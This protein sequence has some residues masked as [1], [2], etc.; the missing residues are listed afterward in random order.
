M[1]KSNNSTLHINHAALFPIFI[2]VCLLGLIFRL[3]FVWEVGQHPSLNIYLAQTDMFNYDLMARD[4]LRQ[5]PLGLRMIGYPLFIHYL[6]FFYQ[7]FGTSPLSFYIHNYIL[8]VLSIFLLYRIG[9][10]H[11]GR[12]AGALAALIFIF[13]KMNY[14]YDAL[15]IHTALSQ[16]LIIASLYFF[17]RFRKNDTVISY[18]GFV[19]AGILL[20]FI[21]IF[22]GFLVLIGIGYLFIDK[23]HW[24]SKTYCLLNIAFCILS[25]IGFNRLHSTDTYRHKFGVHFYIGNHAD[26]SGVFTPIR[27]VRTH[28]QGFAQDTILKAYEETG[29]IE[30]INTYWLKKTVDSY[31]NSPLAVLRVLIKKINLFVNSYE[32]HNNASIYFYETNTALKYFPRIG[33]T[34]IF[35]L[36]LIGM[37][38]T[39][40]Y[41]LEGRYLI[42]PIILLSAMILSVFFC[43]RYRMPTIPFL[44]LFAGLGINQIVQFIKGRDYRSL[45]V[46]GVLAGLLFSWSYHKTPILDKDQDILFWEK[47]D[48][49]RILTNQKRQ[50]ALGDYRNWQKLDPGVKITL[51]GRLGEVG[52]VH[53][54]F[55]VYGEAYQLAKTMNA[56]KRLIY[57]MSV[58]A[59]LYEESFQLQKS[60]K[61]WQELA[62]VKQIEKIARQKIKTLEIAASVLDPNSH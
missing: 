9:A 10:V 23:Q 12:S 60:L 59:S 4:L 44:C 38:A 32:P 43:S 48:A 37:F 1:N 24:K 31:K 45:I 61:V 18:V 13:Y 40:L 56:R 39:L 50:A 49:A 5:D 27:G 30:N 11:W 21:R 19:G 6:K 36:A 15:R 28:A 41:K 26:T 34:V 52:L 33:Y 17:C 2:I 20:S 42:L 55:D 54:F 58:K 8:S 3:A 22:F 51:A 25:I 46:M 29:S 53:E 35:T 7:T 62:K 57:L 16:F 47:R 14:L